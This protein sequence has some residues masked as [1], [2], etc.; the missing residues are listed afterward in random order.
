MSVLQACSLRQLL[1]GF[2]ERWELSQAR[3]LHRLPLPTSFQ[4]SASHCSNPAGSRRSR[5]PCCCDSLAPWHAGPEGTEPLPS[6][7][8]T[9]SLGKGHGFFLQLAVENSP[10][11]ACLGWVAS[12]GADLPLPGSAV[13]T[14]LAR[15]GVA[16]GTRQLLHHQSA[17]P[18]ASAPVQEQV[19]HRRVYRPGGYYGKKGRSV[20]GA[21]TGQRTRV[22]LT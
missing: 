4:A 15:L 14:A 11:F 7:H 18:W 12:S 2:G 17:G 21:H 8:K 22:A 6:A 19:V 13:F 16:G 1:I 10:L 5:L 3:H 20:R 9:L